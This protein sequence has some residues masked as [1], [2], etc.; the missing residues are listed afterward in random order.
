MKLTSVTDFTAYLNRPKKLELADGTVYVKQLKLAERDE[1][2][3][4]MKAL[5]E[6]GD[7]SP[8][9]LG[10]MAGIL[11]SLLTDET[12]KLVFV[13]DESRKHLETELTLEFLRDF[14]DKFWS[15]FNFNPEEVSAAQDKFRG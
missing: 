10:K 9:V 4:Q 13:D 3:A 8:E 1:L 15:R 6:L 5:D 2:Q 14:F 11:S 12:G 7:E